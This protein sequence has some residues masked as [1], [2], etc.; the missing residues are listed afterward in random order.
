MFSFDH[1][2]K[3]SSSPSPPTNKNT[4]VEMI[5]TNFPIS[6]AK[7]IGRNPISLN[8]S[9]RGVRYSVGSYSNA[10]G[11]WSAGNQYMTHNAS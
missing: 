4:Q 2:G 1:L 9:Q 10:H 8:R 11:G 5:G 7:E 3:K 6:T